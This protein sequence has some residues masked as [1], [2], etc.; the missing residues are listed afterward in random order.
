MSR[1]QNKVKGRLIPMIQG[2]YAILSDTDHHL[3]AAWSMMLTMVIEFLDLDTVAITPEERKNFSQVAVANDMWM[4]WF[5]RSSDYPPWQFAHHAWFYG[6]V[7][8]ERAQLLEFKDFGAAHRT[9]QQLANN[10]HSNWPVVGSYLQHQTTGFSAHPSGLCPEAR[11]K[12]HMA[13]T[14]GPPHKKP[15]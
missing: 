11:T 2:R 7:G 9:K 14:N 3:L 10:D 5:G 8:D 12:D 4:V 13:A 15:C 1:L 6:K